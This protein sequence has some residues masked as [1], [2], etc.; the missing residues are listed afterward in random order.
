MVDFN[1]RR[2][3]ESQ[4]NT[5]YVRPD[6]KRAVDEHLAKGSDRRVSLTFNG[7]KDENGALTRNSQRGYLRAD[8]EGKPALYSNSKSTKGKSIPVAD[9]ASIE[10]SRRDQPFYNEEGK[11]AGKVPT[12][13]WSRWKGTYNLPE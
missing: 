13:Y 9:L 3:T 1:D 10:S 12:S 2:L 5:A 7:P 4:K 6:I 8:A 11:R